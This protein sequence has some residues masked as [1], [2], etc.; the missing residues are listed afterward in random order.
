MPVQ[1]YRRVLAIPGIRSLTLL[2]LIAR[3]P[4][5]SVGITLTLHVVDDLH[6]G[7]GAA[8]LVG[9]VATVGS[10]LGAPLLGRL[11]DRHGLRP[12]L[13]VTIVGEAVFWSLA[14]SVSYPMLLVRAAVA[15]PIKLPVF[16]VVRQ[17]IAALVPPAERRQAYA[18]DSMSVEISFMLGPA[19]AIIMVRSL[20]AGTTMLVVGAATVAAGLGLFVL[21]PPVHAAAEPDDAP[22]GAGSERT[23]RWL[24]PAIVQ[25]V[26][27]GA[28]MLVL[29]GCDLSIVAMLRSADQL[30][31]TG[32]VFVCWGG[33]SLVG[34]FMFG[35]LRRPVSPLLLICLLGLTAIPVGL[36]GGWV[37]LCLALLPTGLLCAPSIAASSEAVTRI[38]PAR[39]RGEMLG[40]HGA[41]MT[42]G[43]AIGA[44]LSGTAI[45]RYGPGL[46]FV[47]VGVIGAVVT[48]ALLLVPGR[49]PDG[50]QPAGRAEPPRQRT[51]TLADVGTVPVA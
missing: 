7:Y 17:S 18:L 13:L 35:I 28:A 46:G 49:T 42:I 40:W 48:G 45:D 9:T 50:H 8:G 23:A 29:T 2:A 41:A 16:S 37:W 25:F 15:S 14:P 22:A 11:I 1:P 47:A 24:G 6:R 19:L 21:N 38:A 44:P 30:S 34:G 43:G 31:W 3:I 51:A 5:I 20:S 4:V 36:A 27:V 33:A 32:V 12:V 39:V 10:A 26:A